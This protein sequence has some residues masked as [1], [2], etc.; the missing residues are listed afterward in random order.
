MKSKSNLLFKARIMFIAT[1]VSLKSLIDKAFLRLGYQPVKAQRTIWN[2]PKN[3]RRILENWEGTAIEVNYEEDFCV[4]DVFNPRGNETP[5]S[6]D[7]FVSESKLVFKDK[8][9]KT[10]LPF[11]DVKCTDMNPQRKKVRLRA[12]IKIVQSP[13]RLKNLSRPL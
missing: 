6:Y 5:I 13:E 2:P 11:V 1:I 4:R 3:A 9:V 12:S 10:L 7:D 8:F